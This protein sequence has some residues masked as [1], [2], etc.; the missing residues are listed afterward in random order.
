M[1]SRNRPASTPLTVTAG[2]NGTDATDKPLHQE[3]AEPVEAAPPTSSSGAQP[4]PG[5]GAA[6]AAVTFR[7]VLAADACARSTRRRDAQALNILLALWGK[8]LDDQ[9]G[10]ELL[11]DD[12]EPVCRTLRERLGSNYT[13]KRVGQFVA[14]A[15]RLHL[16]ALDLTGRPRP[17]SLHK[18]AG[19]R[20][21]PRKV[22]SPAGYPRTWRGLLDYRNSTLKSWSRVT[23][24]TDYNHLRQ[25]LEFAD[26]DVPDDRILGGF[27]ATKAG[28]LAL[29]TAQGYSAASLE[30]FSSF[31]NELHRA[32]QRMFPARG[33]TDPDSDAPTFGALLDTHRD[34]VPEAVFPQ[35]A[36][37]LRAFMGYVLASDD[38]AIVPSMAADHDDLAAAFLADRT[39]GGDGAKRVAEHRRHLRA[40]KAT[41][42]L[43]LQS[44]ASQ[45]GFAAALT[46]GIHNSGLT[47]EQVSHAAGM[48]DTLLHAW[49]KSYSRPRTVGTKA[50]RTF[51]RIAALERVLR[52]PEAA[53][54]SLLAT[55]AD[56]G[57]RGDGGRPDESMAHRRRG[58]ILTQLEYRFALPDHVE[59]PARRLIAF[60]R[61]VNPGRRRDGKR[62]VRHRRGEWRSNE[63]GTPAEDITRNTLEGFFGWLRL[64]SDP[65]QARERVAASL[66]AETPDDT[67][68]AHIPS[69]MGRGWQDADLD[70]CQITD[71]QLVTEF[72][73]FTVVRNK[74]WSGHQT[75]LLAKI[76]AIIHPNQGWLAQHPE[77]AERYKGW[78]SIDPRIDPDGYEA[79]A[80]M[81]REHCRDAWQ[82]LE[83][84]T[85]SVERKA[86]RESRKLKRL[87]DVFQLDDPAQALALLER[88]LDEDRPV[89][90]MREASTAVWLRDGLLVG[91][92]NRN[93]LRAYNY[94]IM[95]YRADNTG[96]LYQ[97]QDGS[98][99][100]RYAPHEFK[101]EEGAAQTAY[102][103]PIP[104]DVWPL[105]EA[106]LKAGRPQLS[107]ADHCDRVFLT[108]DQHN[109]HGYGFLPSS[110][111]VRL[112]ELV[113][114]YLPEYRP[115]RA[116][117]WRHIIATSWLRSHP[118]DF[119]NVALIL[120]DKFE[121]VMRNYSHLRVADGL[122]KY[123][124]HFHGLL[125][126]V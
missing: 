103:E 73:E 52:L 89:E 51:E 85:P 45:H 110:I 96:H 76:K 100:L 105:I 115:W 16:A 46:A 64:P 24:C 7:D 5:A 36:S 120:H 13:Q 40:L 49:A 23:Q 65:A 107:G 117:T 102:D 69:L 58:G 31:L 26:T 123:H 98:W 43:I 3:A 62:L 55:R 60:H 11:A 4:I 12:I 8:S 109:K 53:L 74:G 111:S 99:W 50:G 70:L 29:K 77:E 38:T 116:H 86:R 80:R 95:T 78:P 82:A 30:G 61:S 122:Q 71:D 56:A 21:P 84:M 18:N 20:P 125:E 57:T 1:T 88:R 67:V 15:K 63:F 37:T 94:A 22:V 44:Q 97:R 68:E 32:A 17:A 81:W 114:R 39:R 101:N 126:G 2:R 9:V 113:I 35:H 34:H 124:E 47:F 48:T 27:A 112:E 28:F 42:D 121:T 41:A 6:P 25:Y 72:L 19:K 75:L 91:M 59:Q 33:T 54:S 92:I 79:Q 66:A 93:P 119:L 118:N 108:R 83:A 90:R 104:K 10:A 14:A 87:S 106:Y